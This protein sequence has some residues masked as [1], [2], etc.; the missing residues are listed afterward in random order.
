MWTKRFLILVLFLVPS[1]LWAQE[2]RANRLIVGVLR[3][4]PP[5]YVTDAQGEPSGFAVDSIQAIARRAGFQ[6][7]FRSYETWPELAQALTKGAIDVI[8]NFGITESRQKTFL[9]SSSLETIPIH[10]FVRS[11]YKGARNPATLLS[12]R[13]GIMESNVASDILEQYPEALPVVYSTPGEALFELLSGQIESLLY[14]THQ[15]MF[16]AEAAGVGEIIEAV[17]RPVA[18]VKRALAVA[19]ERADLLARLEPAVLDFQASDEYRIIYSRWHKAPSGY[20]TV[21][22][23]LVLSALLLFLVVL[24]MGLWHLRRIR[25]VHRKIAFQ[26]RL[27]DV[28]GEAVIA[29]DLEGSVIFWNQFAQKLYG[30]SEAEVLGRSIFEFTPI[31]RTQDEARVIMENLKL[32]RNWDGEIEVK[33]RD[34][35]TFP[36]EVTNSPLL[37]EAG[38]LIG[39]VGVSSDLTERKRLQESLRQAQRLE[40]VGRLAGGVAHDFNN[41][42]TVISGTVNLLLESSTLSDETREDL[43]DIDN[44]VMRGV[45]LTRQLLAFSRRQVLQPAHMDMCGIVVRMESLLSRL[46]GED[47]FLET[48]LCKEPCIVFAD[49]GQIE[50]VIV[51]LAVNAR[52]AMPKGGTLRIRVDCVERPSDTEAES[53]SSFVRLSVSDTG[54]GISP[55][56]MPHLFEPFYTTKPQD[57]GTGLGLATVHGIV[58]QSGGFIEVESLM[59]QGSQFHVFLP[60]SDS[61]EIPAPFSSEQLPPKGGK[62]RILLVEDDKSIRSILRRAL[63]SL[64]YQV[65]DA[66]DGTSA[67]RLLEQQGGAVDLVITDLVM[68]GMSGLELVEELRK[69]DPDMAVLL[70]SGYSEEFLAA[71]GEE[72]RKETFMEKPFDLKLAA[73]LVREV[74]DRAR[75]AAPT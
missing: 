51:N 12:G 47:L 32:G 55:E 54:V 17:G 74:L 43:L 14:P 73:R 20:W 53:S 50:Q 63:L 25:R 59:D 37:D 4:W 9:Y 52:D 5:Q 72:F 44:Q 41:L 1:P 19:P 62:E 8:P 27:L 24:G 39:M 48:L 40:A 10:I 46:L 26:A 61:E 66:A 35:R 69:R 21:K 56:S 7:H 34:G 67:L 70:M 23:V 29:T 45:R 57:Q 68:P 60:K 3:D 28:V 2:S 71:R 33:H 38:T 18:E 42:L 30:W 58:S 49:P 31:E 22:R 11:S 64:G 6:V 13:V 15:M 65:F 16:L 75:A 36:A